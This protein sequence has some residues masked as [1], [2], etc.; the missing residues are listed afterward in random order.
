M[1]RMRVLPPNSYTEGLGPYVTVFGGGASGR[2]LGLDEALR[3]V[4][5][6]GLVSLQGGEGARA[7]SL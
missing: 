1:D 2:R 4:R 3:G 6:M 5:R 7:G